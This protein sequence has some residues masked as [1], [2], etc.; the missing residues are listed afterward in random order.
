[1]KIFTKRKKL[2]GKSMMVSP[3][4]ISLLCERLAP[5]KDPLAKEKPPIT[6]EHLQWKKDGKPMELKPEEGKTI[7]LGSDPGITSMHSV[8]VMPLETWVTGIVK[9]HNIPAKRVEKNAKKHARLQRKKERE[10][11]G[12]SPPEQGPIFHP[13][14]PHKTV[15]QVRLAEKK[16]TYDRNR[17]K[18]KQVNKK[19]MH[20]YQVGQK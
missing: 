5:R 2:K 19:G 17:K 4:S 6:A 1:L 20:G 7:V 18:S 3:S 12:E 8:N 13:L 9:N 11:K 14:F 10:A 16:K 15:R